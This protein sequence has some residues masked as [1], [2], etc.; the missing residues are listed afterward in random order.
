MSVRV[1]VTKYAGECSICQNSVAAYEGFAFV[2]GRGRWKALCKS[3]NCAE[4][5]GVKA[6]V[7]AMVQK[8]NA[9]KVRKLTAEGV[10]EMPFERESLP[11]VR[12]FPGARWNPT[13]KVWTVSLDAQDRMRVLEIA[14][15]L[16]LDVDP[17]LRKVD[18]PVFV[19][20]AKARAKAAGGYP[21]Q[22]KGI[23]WLAGRDVA[24]LADDM[25]L[26]KTFQTIMAIDINMGTIAIVPASVKY[27][28]QDEIAKWRPEL[29]C[30]VFNGR[31]NFRWP[32]PGEV[33][34]MN[35]EVLVKPTKPTKPKRKEG[36]S[37]RVYARK[38]R[39][40]QEKKDSYKERLASFNAN[41]KYLLAPSKPSKPKQKRGEDWSAFKG[42]LAAY[43]VKVEEHKKALE[44][45][46]V[47][48][49]KMQKRHGKN[50]I[51]VVDEAHGVKNYKAGRTKRVT[52]LAAICAKTWFLTGTPLLNRPLD[53][54]GILSAGNM[55]RKV[56]ATWAKFVRLFNGSK[57]R[58]G[59]YEFGDV[60]PSVPELLR[61]VMLRRLRT[62]VLPDLPTKTHQTLTVECP[63]DLMADL[64]EMWDEYQ[65]QDMDEL[66]SFEM[67]SRVRAALAASR[68][69]AALEV[70]EQYEEQEVPLIVFSAHKK[71]V[72]TIAAREGWALITGDTDVLK[73]RNIVKDFQDGKLKGVACTILA[74]GVGITLTR[75]SHALFIDLEWNPSLNAQAED[76]ICRIGQNANKVQ[77]A[78]M[79]SNHPM[80]QHVLKLLAEKAA[81]IDAAIEAEVEVDAAKLNAQ[82]E[83]A[84]SRI[85]LVEETD[86]EYAARM[87]HLDEVVERAERERIL[88]KVGVKLETM[89][90]KHSRV[91]VPQF[92]DELQANLRDAWSQMLGMCDGAL[93]QDDVGFNKPD[94]SVAHWTLRV[95]D[96]EG[97]LELAYLMLRKYHRQ[98]ADSYPALY[99]EHA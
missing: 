68:T 90:G 98:L 30:T 80:D 56:F 94:A 74:A 1:I 62:E 45:Q 70:V 14:D 76:R 28:W 86:E 89:R 38:L 4:R 19:L 17:S 7:E 40:H 48:I 26:G 35:Y 81:V 92:T 9:P 8:A 50:T 11:L 52:A 18:S 47:F 10:L 72:E 20:E 3:L 44:E 84:G 16:G 24:L 73:R 37:E 87:R 67:F 32:E 51:L 12:S 5:A 6:E 2:K 25:G 46:K 77:I 59:G 75:A 53:L 27:N 21:Y 65:E 99:P 33:V 13:D 29:R 34:I 49:E 36:D 15:K 97:A 91:K 55:S 57:N 22:I 85:E 71:G 78:R 82:A 31:S 83:G 61:R 54:F 43:E 39:L 64:D 63:S 79:V 69:A 88:G 23:E 66:P 42:R 96:D 41:L 60:D 58:W 95:L 93:S